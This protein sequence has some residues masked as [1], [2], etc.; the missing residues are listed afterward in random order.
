MTEARGK[1]SGAGAPARR[2][3]APRRDGGRASPGPVIRGAGRP[4][5]RDMRVTGAASACSESTKPL[6]GRNMRKVAPRMGASSG[7][8]ERWIPDVRRR[9]A[10][11]AAMTRCDGESVQAFRAG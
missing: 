3:G 6:T 5:R 2:T 11:E 7:E 10:G 9:A 4:S 1:E 8:V